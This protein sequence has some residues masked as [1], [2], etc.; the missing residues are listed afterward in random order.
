MANSHC[1]PTDV[2]NTLALQAVPDESVTAGDL[3]CPVPQGTF[4]DMLMDIMIFHQ[5]T[6]NVHHK[7]SVPIT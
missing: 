4:G 3:L 2:S 6:T 5:R 1:I 7:Y